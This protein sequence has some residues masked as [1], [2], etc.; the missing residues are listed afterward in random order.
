MADDDKRP[1]LKICIDNTESKTD[2]EASSDEDA[3]AL[4]SE[5]SIDESSDDSSSSDEEPSDAESDPPDVSDNWFN[6]QYCFF[7]CLPLF[8]RFLEVNS[9]W[10]QFRHSVNVF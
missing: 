2:S 7:T 4:V 5:D 9:S 6:W 1:N 3:V 8:T 10:L